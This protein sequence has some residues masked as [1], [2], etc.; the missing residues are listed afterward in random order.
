MAALFDGAVGYYHHVPGVRQ[1]LCRLCRRAGIAGNCRGRI[2]PRHGMILRSSCVGS[3]LTSYRCYTC[4]VSIDAGT[5]RCA[6]VC[7]IPLRLYRAPLVVS[8]QVM[9]LPWH[10]AKKKIGL[11]A[12]GLA[13]IGP[14]GGLEGWRWILIIEGLLVCPPRR[15]RQATDHD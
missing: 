9:L 12:R 4:L 15:I 10:E 13:E 2:A 6:L 8:G 11:L 14:R 7:F 5:W 1:E 3:C